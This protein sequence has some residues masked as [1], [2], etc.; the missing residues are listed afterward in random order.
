VTSSRRRK[1][2]GKPKRRIEG[3]NDRKKP[4]AKIIVIWFR[5]EGRVFNR[6][7]VSQQKGRGEGMK[8]GKG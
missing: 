7:Q 8:K 4:N 1:R 3:E 2:M 6:R 5:L